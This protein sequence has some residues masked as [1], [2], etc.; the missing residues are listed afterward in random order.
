MLRTMLLLFVV[1]AGSLASAQVKPI[2]IQKP[3]NVQMKQQTPAINMQVDEATLLRRDVQKLRAEVQDL[4]NQV[5]ALRQSQAD[6]PRCSADRNMHF[7]VQQLE[8]LSR[9]RGV[10]YGR[11]KVRCTLRSSLTESPSREWLGFSFSLQAAQR[12]ASCADLQLTNRMLQL[13]LAKP[14]RYLTPSHMKTPIERGTPYASTFRRDV[15]QQ[16]AKAASCC[17]R[18]TPAPGLHAFGRGRRMAV[19]LMPANLHH[20]G[21]GPHHAHRSIRASQLRSEF[22]A[23]VSVGD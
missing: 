21:M 17:R 20:L 10:R 15:R 3:S 22:V 12:C 7:V 2:Q 18:A 1:A 6:H 19:Q 9:R 5:A 16:E 13:P 4:K 8:R 11:G 23:R 14:W